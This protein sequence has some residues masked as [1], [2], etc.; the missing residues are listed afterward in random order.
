MPRIPSRRRIRA[1]IA[2]DVKHVDCQNRDRERGKNKKDSGPSSS[3]QR[4]KKKGRFD[5]ECLR[6]S[7]Q[8]Q[9]SALGSTQPQRV[10]QQP[11]RGHGVAKEVQGTVF[12]AD[13]MEL[14][15]GEFDLIL[16]MDWLVRHWASLAYVTKRVFLRTE[17]DKEVVV[18]DEHR[19]Y[20]SNVEFGIELLPSMAPVSIASYRMAPNELT[21]LKAQLQEFLDQDFIRPSVSPWGVPI[22]FIKKKG[23]SLRMCID[24]RQLNKLTVRNKYM[25]PRI[26]DLFDQFRG[27]SVIISILWKGFFFNSAPLSKLL[28]KGVPFVWIDTQEE[29]FEKLKLVL[30]QAP[31][32]IQPKFEYHPSKANVVANALSHRAMSDLRV[33][34]V[35]LSLFDNGSL[36]AELQVNLTWIEQIRDR[37]L[38]DETLGLRFRQIGS[39]TIADFGLNSDDLKRHEIEYSVRDFVFI[40]VSPWKKVL[41]FGQKS[42]LSYR[43]IGLYWVLKRVGL[44]AY[45]LELP[46]ELD[47]FQ[48]V[49]HISTLRWYHSDPSHVVSVEEIEEKALNVNFN[50][51]VLV[52]LNEVFRR[53]FW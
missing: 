29:I 32:L 6:Q 44:V 15:F 2:E 4:L 37:Q 39:G 28:R 16:G 36:L 38:R 35:C 19:D 10:V 26:D 20:L 51:F 24:Y 14:L 27:A 12:L 48:D 3:V 34:F 31:I 23:R 5:G 49:F 17:D 43:F 22:L 21:E 41:R 46:P 33:M 9:A 18:I 13:L 42:K 50:P 53:W 7:N 25:L 40:K 1:K 11:P 8:M 47:R 52:V 30:T 45:Q